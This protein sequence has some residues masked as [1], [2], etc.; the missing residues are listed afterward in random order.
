MGRYLI[1]FELFG[2]D[3]VGFGSLVC[4]VAW[5]WFAWICCD[6]HDLL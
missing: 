6:L 2:L 5:F 1:K 4:A 3:V